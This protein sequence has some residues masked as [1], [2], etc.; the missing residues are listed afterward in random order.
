VQE[1]AKKTGVEVGAMEP[2]AL[3]ARISADVAQWTDVVERAAIE[4]H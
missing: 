2:N 4:K 3:K 1:F